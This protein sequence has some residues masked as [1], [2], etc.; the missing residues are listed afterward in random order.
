MEIGREYIVPTVSFAYGDTYNKNTHKTIGS[1]PFIHNFD[2]NIPQPLLR[3]FDVALGYC[4]SIYLGLSA[5]CPGIDF[6]V[7]SL[8]IDS[9]PDCI[10]FY[11]PDLSTGSYAISPNTQNELVE[12]GTIWV[13]LRGTNTLEDIMKDLSWIVETLPMAEDLLPGDD[14]EF[15]LHVTAVAKIILPD[16]LAYVTSQM[17]G[18]QSTEKSA[19]SSS[20]GTRRRRVVRRVCFTGH[21]LGGALATALH[22]LYNAKRSEISSDL[23]PPSEAFT[24]G[25]PLLLHTTAPEVLNTAPS[26]VALRDHT[27]NIVFQLDPVPRLLGVHDFPTYVR[28]SSV[29]GYIDTLI[30]R[31]DRKNYRPF[32]RYYCLRH[33]LSTPPSAQAASSSSSASAAATSSSTTLVATSVRETEPTESGA[34]SG[35]STAPGV[36]DAC[37][38]TANSESATAI[39]SSWHMDF[40]SAVLFGEHPPFKLSLTYVADPQ[41]VLG[42]LSTFPTSSTEF[43]FSALHDHSADISHS[44]L[45]KAIQDQLSSSTD[46]SG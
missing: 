23:F 38:T 15:P 39:E 42:L 36:P 24:V 6:S 40:A 46:T 8:G 45:K 37:G 16:I 27:H 25:S 28:E 1:L 5:L 14:F 35:V 26:V 44:S 13:V 22:V 34:K 33:T 18:P 10:A 31:V 29:G 2:P 12:E 9:K 20:G 4:K 41:A 19:T 11:T 7:L 43:L 32:G 30:R 3:D 17:D 21:S